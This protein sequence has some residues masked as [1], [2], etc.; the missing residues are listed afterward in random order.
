MTSHET[1]VIIEHIYIHTYIHVPLRVG[2]SGTHSSVGNIGL[3]T[4]TYIH[5]PL[6]VGCGGTHSPVGSVG[7]H[8]IRGVAMA[9]INM[10]ERNPLGYGV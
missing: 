4:F 10:M 3:S 5:A 8:R 9:Q 2:C 6:R 7:K 1:E